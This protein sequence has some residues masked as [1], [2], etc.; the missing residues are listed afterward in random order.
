MKIKIGLMM[1]LFYSLTNLVDAQNTAISF[2]LNATQT[3]GTYTARDYIKLMPGFTSSGNFSAQ[4]NEKLVYDLGS[5]GYFNSEI[6]PPASVNTNSP[7]GCTIGSPS[8]TATGG[9]TY[10]LP[11]FA[12]LGTGG[13]QPSIS[14]VYNS[15]GGN[16]V[17][18][19]S[20]DIAGLS[21]ITRVPQTVYT[22]GKG[23]GVNLDAD[24]RFAL[25]GNRLLKL[26]GNY[27]ELGTTYETE[28]M[29]FSKIET[30][31]FGSSFYFK[32]STKDGKIIEYGNSDNSRAVAAGSSV[33]YMWRIS[34]ITDANGNFM[35][36][37]YRNENGESVIDNIDYTGN[38]N[39][40]LQ[41][42]NQLQF[43]YVRRD[44]KNTVHIANAEIDQ[45][46]LLRQVKSVCEGKMARTYN[47]D[48]TKSNFDETH[49]NKITETGSDGKALNP[50]IINWGEPLVQPY[51]DKDDTNF[52]G[53][54][55]L[56]SG[57]FN[58][59]GRTDYFTI[60][61][62]SGRDY[63]STD[64][65]QLYTTNQGGQ[66]FHM[67]CQGY[68]TDGFKGIEIADGDND[69]KDDIY[70]HTETSKYEENEFGVFITYYNNYIYHQFDGNS[71]MIDSVYDYQVGFRNAGCQTLIDDFDGDS[72]TDF[73]FLDENK[74]FGDFF[75]STDANK[76]GISK[77]NF[78]TPDKVMMVDFNGDGKKDI[79]VIKKDTFC[80][81]YT[82]DDAT[83]SFITIYN[84]S[85]VGF[86]TY[87]HRIFPGDFNGDGKTDLLTWNTQGQWNVDYSTGTT[88]TSLA[89]SNVPILQ[90]I[91]PDYS[92]VD[93][94]YTIA[95]FNGDGKSDILE[96]YFNSDNTKTINI[97]YS[98]GKG[99]K[100]ET[101]TGSIN[102]SWILAGKSSYD[103]FDDLNGDG[104]ADILVVRGI[105]T[106]DHILNFHAYEQTGMV[107][108]ITNGY[109]QSVNFAYES[110]ST[111][112]VTY[113]KS[114]SSLFPVND[115]QAP[116]YVVSTLSTP[117]GVGGNSSTSYSYSGAKIHRQGLGFLGF[118][119]V[120]SEN[121]V[122]KR[123][124][125][126]IT[127]LETTGANPSYRPLTQEN[128]IYIKTTGQMLSSSITNF[129]NAQPVVGSKAWFSY[130]ST[131]TESNRSTGVFVI[132]KNNYN[133][134][135]DGNICTITKNFGNYFTE[136][137][138]FENYVRAGSYIKA[139]GTGLPN[140]PQTIT[141]TRK[142]PDDTKP[143][144]NQTKYT[145]DTVTGSVLTKTENTNLAAA[146]Q[147]TTT[148]SNFDNFGNPR[149]VNT[150]CT[151]EGGNVNLTKTYTYEESKGR[152]M[153]SST[154]PLGITVSYTYDPIFGNVL[155]EKLSNY[156]TQTE[157]TYDAWGR[158][159]GKSLP[160][161]NTTTTT[162]SWSTDI[163]AGKPLYYAYTTNSAN[164][165]WSKTYYDEFGRTLKEETVG[166]GGIGKYSTTKYLSNGLTDNQAA[167]I[168]LTKTSQTTYGYWD[169]GRVKTA[170]NNITGAVVTTTYTYGENK[171]KTT[172]DG[173]DYTKIFDNW[174]N[175]K[176]SDEPAPGGSIY[177][178]Y[179][180]HGKPSYIYSPASTITMLYDDLG[181]QTSLTDPDAGTT[182]YR[183]DPLN[184][185]TYQKSA[186]GDE[187]KQFYDTYGRLQKITDGVGITQYEYEYYTTPGA[188]FGKLQ[189]QSTIS[190]GPYE[191]YTYDELGRVKTTTKY[192]D[193][194]NQYTYTTVYDQAGNIAQTTY[195]GGDIVKNQYDNY[196]V[197]NQVLFTSADGA[198]TNTPVW[199]LN[200][201]DA[202]TLAYTLGNGLTT[203]KSYDA[204]KGYSLSS[205]V[206]ANVGN[207]VQSCYYDFNAVN[208]NLN[209][210]EDRRT[211]YALKETFLY[212][213]L[214]RLTNWKVAQ[215]AIDKFSNGITYKTNKSGNIETKTDAGTYSYGYAGKPHQVSSLLTTS[216]TFQPPATPQNITYT[217]FG[218]VDVLT[219]NNYE[220]SITYG[221]D[222][223]RCKSVMKLSGTTL[224][225]KYYDGGYEKK[226]SANGT[227]TQY[228]YVPA[229]DGLAA[230]FIKT[231]TA[232]GTLYYVHTDYLGSITA[233][234]NATG[235]IVE[236]Y[237]YDPWG[238]RRNPADWSFTNVTAPTLLSRGFTGHE[239]IDELTLINMNG[240]VYDPVLGMFISCDN[241][242]Q[243]PTQSQNFNR[244]SYCFGNPLKYTD[245]DGEWIHIL[246]GAVIGGIIN[247]A[248]H[249]NQIHNFWDGVKAFGVGA[250]G[251]ALVAATGGAALTALGGGAA[252][253]G[254]GGFIAGSLS[255]GV[256]YTF[257]SMVTSIGN[258]MF[259]GDPMPTA[260][261]FVTGMGIS[262]LT[263][264]VFQ[265][266]NASLH[267]RNFFT[268]N[269]PISMPSPIPM[270]A[271]S[272]NSPESKLN[273]DGMR[274]QLLDMPAGRTME[275][276][277]QNL[278]LKLPNIEV[279]FADK[280]GT[281]VVYQGLDAAGKVRYVGITERAAATRFAEHAAS[282]GT[283][284][285][286][287]IYRVVNGAEG[288][289]RM[290]ARIWEQTLINQYGLG[291]NGGLLLNKINSIAPKYWW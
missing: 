204:T 23:G 135:V 75:L 15:Q 231:G 53:D 146:M 244:Y 18:G 80:K 25:D 21:A 147:V 101:N 156:A 279:N 50:T 16:G 289:S 241:F 182:T 284:K 152:F 123:K 191:S 97:Y 165:A 11:I 273:T 184:R 5:S 234:T 109:N 139:G 162:L 55:W 160:D 20:W 150:T 36:F 283:G 73:I 266:V 251:G 205:I 81:I 106:P 217:S 254:G 84:P 129:T 216:T 111:G 69:G 96:F 208:G 211:G 195:P 261:Q 67:E 133:G 7:V 260:K 255:A 192:I 274:T 12:S 212:D 120:V 47:F 221:S 159:T 122:A 112:K 9:A 94:N 17:L 43:A 158:L 59:D 230:V 218:K 114:S 24:D 167:Y 256:G 29:T 105:G 82:Y 128:Y 257:G 68:L 227:T 115:I 238:R 245:P 225:T 77:P 119:T 171:V 196:G 30:L 61:R 252:A 164:S 288:L 3:T 154:D 54:K 6:Q 26:V 49:L 33:P 118:E 87:W 148:Y 275:Q 271:L 183:Y 290:D 141:V 66:S 58:G 41:T 91:D 249:W 207:Q 258:N 173:K 137:T 8:V 233:L 89:T 193:A 108:K 180:S 57:D 151:S 65:W 267:G 169:D 201:S 197:L 90:T 117:D 175:L 166:F 248:T 131:V 168:G 278:S 265:G 42:Y 19:R 44:D 276:E 51:N 13:M 38:V 253:V 285:E 209:S 263:A 291:K 236:Q 103:K 83:K 286:N 60:P 185:L 76:A 92:S 240:R 14:I 124:T 31:A 127:T 157:N 203:T 177:Y 222:Q 107:S 224:Y 268:G 237:A 259:F 202:T 113:T 125:N 178:K 86:P 104:K 190:S 239:H 32:V 144:T 116:I 134:D 198:N 243:S 142:H 213:D 88:F 246:I 143:F 62:I 28:T 39:A 206:T 186:N 219:D 79:M 269:L 264:G 98:T 34:K 281:N 22:D 110:L 2:N 85:G 63:N 199:T 194:T 132:T 174:G 136:T 155:S 250:A 126:S 56:Y 1:W 179:F 149:S 226:I 130:P 272:Y 95:D 188:E 78:N 214:Y 287:L 74:N 40:G 187:T 262:M 52:F 200:T 99:F 93:N 121:T 270:P 102:L 232:P 228:T 153:T 45:T 161:G 189:K 172:S 48:Y 37:T 100:K 176:Q 223:Q 181:Q 242:V 138:T 210:R 145:Y 70:F 4:I 72:K 140:K 46:L 10:S 64:Q 235:S 247:T 71:L 163:G 220:L 215:N 229:G 35:T 282:I 280:A 27:G 277:F 170:T